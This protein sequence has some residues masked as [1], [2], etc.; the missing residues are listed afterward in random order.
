VTVDAEGSPCLI[1]N[2]YCTALKINQPTKA[3]N[4]AVPESLVKAIAIATANKAGKA[5]KTALP[6]TFST[7]PN[8]CN[9]NK[10]IVP[11]VLVVRLTIVAPI[12]KNK[13]AIGNIA[14]GNIIPRESLAKNSLKLLSPLFFN[15]PSFLPKNF[16]IL[17]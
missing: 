9:P 16:H 2:E 3:D 17:I 13:P 1:I 10:I 15:C 7:L 11:S 5:E 4:P 12:P 6:D 8:I 14:T